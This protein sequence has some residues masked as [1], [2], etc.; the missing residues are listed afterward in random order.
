MT[1]LTPPSKLRIPVTVVLLVLV[2]PFGLVAWIL[3]SGSYRGDYL[4]APLVRAG[5]GI[6][7]VSALP[8]LSVVA[9][10][11][12]GVWPDPNP[13]PIG[14]GLLL[15]AGGGLGTVILGFGVAAVARREA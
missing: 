14:F 9:L 5:F 10:S 1:D 7:I 6:A 8:L 15:V 3:L 2:P 11:A 12:L 4:R 13:N